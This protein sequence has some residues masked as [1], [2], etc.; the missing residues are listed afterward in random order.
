MSERWKFR[1]LSV[2]AI[3]FALLL[4]G[5]VVVVFAEGGTETPMLERAHNTIVKADGIELFRATEVEVGGVRYHVF[6]VWG[7]SSVSMQVIRAG[8]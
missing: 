5:A 6:V 3:V 2:I 7:A 1:L 4:I 8:Q